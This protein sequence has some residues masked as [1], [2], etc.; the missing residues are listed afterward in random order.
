MRTLPGSKEY[1]KKRMANSSNSS[2]PDEKR[3][4]YNY[5]S[6][7]TIKE[8]AI[9]KVKRTLERRDAG[10]SISDSSESS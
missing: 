7:Y 6:S 1:C 8:A 2:E 4:K 10:Y 5:K 3:H 9:K